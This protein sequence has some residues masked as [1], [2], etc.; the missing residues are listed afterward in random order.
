M[1][2]DRRC[3]AEVDLGALRHNYRLVKSKAEDAAVMAVVKADAYGHGDV[4]VVTLLDEEGADR[5]AVSGFEEAV[6]LRRVGVA[7]PILILGYTGAHNAAA[8][9]VNDI[10]QTVFSLEY[11]RELSRAAQRA[12]V[13]VNV[14]LKV[15]TGMGRIGFTA[16]DDFEAA[17]EEM[18]EV[19]SMPGL[20]V[21]GIFTHFAVADSNIPEDVEYTKAQYNVFER[22][23]QALKEKGH[24]I[25]VAHCCNSAGTF[26]WPQ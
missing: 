23:I 18:N 2:F 13:T 14:H 7:K 1:D 4:A 25:A 22:V 5:F 20:A 26:A 21:V 6:R 17:V 9:A 15:D 19:C 11:A 3:W 24:S 12:G 10:M 16:R 8:L